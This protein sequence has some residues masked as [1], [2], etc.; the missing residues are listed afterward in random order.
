MKKLL[1]CTF[2][3]SA[4]SCP[5][6]SGVIV[7]RGFVRGADFAQFRATRFENFRDAKTAANLNQLAARDHHFL[8]LRGEM[9]QDEDERGGAIVHHGRC[10]GRA[11]QREIVLEIS[12]AMTA[13]AA[14]KIVFEIACNLRPDRGERFDTPAPSGARPKLV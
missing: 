4:V 5:S 7:S 2:R 3:I 10:F 12:R 8:F 9:P 13:F 14:G 6:D 11:E 1:R